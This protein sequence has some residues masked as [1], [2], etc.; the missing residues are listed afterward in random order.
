MTII[1]NNDHHFRVHIVLL[2]AAILMCFGTSLNAQ[3]SA[4]R[5]GTERGI[6]AEEIDQLRTWAYSIR[7]SLRT[8]GANNLNIPYLDKADHLRSGIEEIVE[9][10][11]LF[12]R[13]HDELLVR[14]ILNRG[15]HF[16]DLILDHVD[17]SDDIGYHQRLLMLSE[18]FDLAREAIEQDLHILEGENRLH[19][20][21][22]FGEMFALKAFQVN[23][24]IVHGLAQFLIGKHILQFYQQ[25]LPQEALMRLQNEQI[26][27]VF[28]QNPDLSAIFVPS[29]ERSGYYSSIPSNKHLIVFHPRF[30]FQLDSFIDLL[31]HEIFHVIHYTYT[32]QEEDWVREGLAQ[33]VEYLV[34][35]RFNGYIIQSERE[36]PW[37]AL[38]SSYDITNQQA[39]LYGHHF[40][41]F[42]YLY[43]Q[44]GQDELLWKLTTQGE[45]LNKKGAELIDHVLKG[46]ENSPR[47][48]QNFK[49]SVRSFQVARVH[50]QRSFVSGDNQDQYFIAHSLSNF[51]VTTIEDKNET[52]RWIDSLTPYTPIRLNI[53][54]FQQN[55]IQCQGCDVYFIQQ[56]FPYRVTQE[57]PSPLEGWELVL[58]IL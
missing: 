12:H 43:Q 31:I 18:I 5:P 50:N 32:Q 48:C 30:L 22:S 20:F 16:D 7:R 11:S 56:H 4:P 27:L 15:L 2:V 33:L 1:K 46:Q 44:C 3:V 9:N 47:H 41:Y 37:T 19:D 51:P 6:N 10:S 26:A 23:S 40:L 42:Y 49:E 17:I 24:T 34:R 13:A 14:Y 29:S 36:N 28:D 8:L 55:P 58:I 53:R 45:A 38:E 35:G 39:S 52:Q 54:N 21:K 57:V 25:F